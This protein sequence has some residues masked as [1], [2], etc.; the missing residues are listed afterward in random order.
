MAMTYP[1]RL[2]LTSA[3]GFCAALTMAGAFTA[4]AE[5]PP[6]PAPPKP[7]SE[8]Q[9]Y[10][11]F[12]G[13]Y[14]A[15]RF[16]YRQRDITSATDFY[17]KVLKK[18]AKNRSLVQR[19]LL[20]TAQD[21]R[22]D[23]AI[24]LARQLVALDPGSKISHLVLIVDA[25]ADGRLN[26]VLAR[27]MS[28]ERNGIYELMA[29]ILEGWL[30]LERGDFEAALAAI[31]PI[32][33]K[34]AFKMYHAYHVALMA[35]ISGREDIAED[36][37]RLAM[38][39][40]P[41][42]TLRVISVYS[43]FLLR[44]G[45]YEEAVALYEGFRKHN[46]DSP[47]LDSIF[48]TIKETI[49]PDHVVPNAQAGMAEA[50]FGA[51]S[52]LPNE[53][54]GD[55][56][57]IYAHLALHL[58]PD[59]PIVELL[60]G[61]ILDSMG[62]Y[63]AAIKT[64]SGIAKESPY[65]WSARLR[66]AADLASVERVDESVLILGEMVVENPQRSDAAIAL[67]DVL[68]RNERFEEAV[69]Y[70]DTAIARTEAIEARHWSLYYSRGVTLERI[71]QWSRA[72]A[73]FLKALELQPDQPLVLNYLGYSWV[74]QGINLE[75]ALELIERAVTLRPTDGYIIDSLGWA[76]YRLGDFKN[77]VKHLERAV[78]LRADDPIIT[79]HLGDIYWRVGRELEARFQWERALVLGAAEDAAVL[80]RQK[81]EEGLADIEEETP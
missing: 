69:S 39:A 35:S 66:A 48:G 37:F 72:E 49:R 47:W 18:D 27:V 8:I 43:N 38:T 36:N 44:D 4:A 7:H 73:D 34:Q 29:P 58:R 17:L 78:E 60:V 75:Y 42:G 21:G 50:L 54:A 45:R 11:G 1:F 53:T 51:A 16:A 41:G 70:Y 13:N 59:F 71:D 76:F 12:S 77:A 67:A 10:S 19:A 56:G 74:E 28:I 46:P 25:V 68:R 14:L 26:D 30:K 9:S 20:L 32:A 33:T 2:W 31:E 3:L 79:D 63:D 81:L 62:R 57:L 40:V 22:I 80:I 64:Y 15:G 52:A 61:E 6:D 24:P 65:S 5:L 23:Q 55:T